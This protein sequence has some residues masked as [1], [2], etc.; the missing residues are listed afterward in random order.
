MV[1]Q[2][3]HFKNRL[4][5]ILRRSP[6]SWGIVSLKWRWFIIS[7]QLKQVKY[8]GMY[9]LC[10]V[11]DLCN[12]TF[13]N[14]HLLPFCFACSKRYIF[15]LFTQPLGLGARYGC[16]HVQCIWVLVSSAPSYIW[17]DTIFICH[18]HLNKQGFMTSY[19]ISGCSLVRQCQARRADW[20]ILDIF[21]WTNR[22]CYPVFTRKS[23]HC[24]QSKAIFILILSNMSPILLWLHFS[25]FV[26]DFVFFWVLCPTELC[27]LFIVFVRLTDCKYP[28][29]QAG[30]GAD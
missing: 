10:I 4:S 30:C 29:G 5:L 23:G 24:L 19:Q 1:F 6:L 15:S 2:N 21:T 16:D 25:M 8:T 22:N 9:I 7:I 14:I 12:D 20:L 26:S 18:D 17:R 11:G 13:K 27:L 28:L 3:R